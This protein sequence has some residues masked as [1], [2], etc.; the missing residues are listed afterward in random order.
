M[1]WASSVVA[2]RFEFESDSMELFAATQ[3]HTK[4][5]VMNRGSVTALAFPFSLDFIQY[6]KL[7]N[8]NFSM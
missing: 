1:T 2:N 7:K 4:G 3:W 6:Q 5:G 8:L